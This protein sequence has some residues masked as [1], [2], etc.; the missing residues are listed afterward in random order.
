MKA[1]GSF[2]DENEVPIGCSLAEGKSLGSQIREGERG[3]VGV[4][5]TVH[6]TGDLKGDLAL[7]LGGIELVPVSTGSQGEIPIIGGQRRGC[8]LFSRRIIHDRRP[9]ENGT[10]CDAIDGSTN[11]TGID[12]TDIEVQ[13]SEIHNRYD[14]G[15]SR[16][17]LRP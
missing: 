7:A 9:G 2:H 17:E 3:M 5:L 1:T 13:I 12:A 10:L 6:L 4:H 14:L 11:P 16:D 8:T 15:I